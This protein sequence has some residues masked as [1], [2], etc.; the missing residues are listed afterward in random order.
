MWPKCPWDNTDKMNVTGSST[1]IDCIDLR[2]EDLPYSFVLRTG[3]AV[4]TDVRMLRR[5]FRARC[6]WSGKDVTLY[7][8]DGKLVV[9][10]WSTWRVI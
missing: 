6:S 7:E 1:S 4:G 8:Q 9:M 3:R 2:R 10:R 5:V